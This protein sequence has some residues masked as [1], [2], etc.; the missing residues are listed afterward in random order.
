MDPADPCPILT[1]L[2]H[3]AR[4]ATLDQKVARIPTGSGW[5]FAITDAGEQNVTSLLGST[6]RDALDALTPPTPAATDAQA[7]ASALEAAERAGRGYARDGWSGVDTA[8]AA[9][10][11]SGSSSAAAAGP[12]RLEAEMA[13]NRGY[14]AERAKRR[15]AW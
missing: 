2:A 10:L 12:Y 4:R 5:Q 8:A 13:F 15:P 1:D 7:K 3:K 9:W 14:R 6:F 11:A